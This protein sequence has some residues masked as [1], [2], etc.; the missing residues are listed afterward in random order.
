[1][2]SFEDDDGNF[3]NNLRLP[4]T[5]EVGENGSSGTAPPNVPR[6]FVSP[7]SSGFSAVLRELISLLSGL[8]GFGNM[9]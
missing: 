8:C 6:L 1:M 3:G 5:V 9:Q 4:H 2:V 7:I